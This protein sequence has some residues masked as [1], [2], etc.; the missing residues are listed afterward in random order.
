MRKAGVSVHSFEEAPCAPLQVVWA[1]TDCAD[2]GPRQFPCAP[3][4]SPIAFWCVCSSSRR[5]ASAAGGAAASAAYGR[6]YFFAVACIWLPVV[7]MLLKQTRTA[8]HAKYV[9]VPLRRLRPWQ[10]LVRWRGCELANVVLNV[11]N[12]SA[13]GNTHQAATSGEAHLRGGA[14]ESTF[15]GASSQRA[16]PLASEHRLDVRAWK[17]VLPG[18]NAFVCAGRSPRPNIHSAGE[19]PGVCLHTPCHE[20]KTTP[21]Q[22]AQVDGARA[23][24]GDEQLSRVRGVLRAVGREHHSGFAHWAVVV[25][26]RRALTGPG[27]CAPARAAGPVVCAPAPRRGVPPSG[28]R[29]CAGT[30]RASAG[31]AVLPVR[32]DCGLGAT[33]KLSP[34]GDS[35][36]EFCPIPPYFL[37]YPSLISQKWRDRRFSCRDGGATRQGMG[38]KFG[39]APDASQPCTGAKSRSEKGLALLRCL[40]GAQSEPQIDTERSTVTL[41]QALVPTPTV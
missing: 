15:L 3:R 28:W 7:H 12:W 40:P 35:F 5:C 21:R 34:G 11:Q 24:V 1:C 17:N 19:L 10:M 26:H 31:A 22:R 32:V 33:K 23:Q 29:R 8:G 6:G 16:Q 36:R 20:M 14:E 9:V 27:V 30:A 18:S 41:G 39:R 38:T 4:S 2:C 37:G 25:A 13:T